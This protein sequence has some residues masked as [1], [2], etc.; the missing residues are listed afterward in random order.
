MNVSVTAIKKNKS[1]F[2]ILLKLIK[3]ANEILICLQVYF[4]W[5]ECDGLSSNSNPLKKKRITLPFS[6]IVVQ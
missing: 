6:S 5:T 4:L 2:F 3:M 1:S